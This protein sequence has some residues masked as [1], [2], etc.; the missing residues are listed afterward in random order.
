MQQ[1]FKENYI[2]QQK[3]KAAER[4]A[5]LEKIGMVSSSESESTVQQTPRVAR[6]PRPAE[7]AMRAVR[8]AQNPQSPVAAQSVNTA[9]AQPHAG[10][11]VRT[12]QPRPGVSVKPREVQRS[13]QPDVRR[14]AQ[15]QRPVS[16]SQQRPTGPQQRPTG[17]QQSPATPPAS[18]AA[19]PVRNSD[20]TAAKVKA[21]APAKA[22]TP[23]STRYG[24]PQKS[25]TIPSYSQRRVKE[26]T[27]EQLFKK[28]LS[29]D[30]SRAMMFAL[31][32]KAEKPDDG[33][34]VDIINMGRISA[35]KK[36]KEADMKKR[37]SVG[38]YIGR[39][40]AA[41]GAVLLAVIVFV[42]STVALIAHGKSM[43]LRDLLVNS[44]MQ[45]SATKWVPYVFLS[46]E[47]VEEILN[48]SDEV[49]EDKVSIED[50]NKEN[51]S[52]LEDEWAN[53]K[54]GMI[55][56]TVSGSTFKAYVLLIKDP[57]RVFVGTSVDDYSTATSG[58]DVFQAAERYGAVACTNG[59]EFLDN[60]GF[61]T[62]FKPMGL[63]YSQG[64]CVNNDGSKKT[65]LGIT[66]DN[67]LIVREEMTKKEADELHIRDAVSFQNGNTLIQRDGDEIIVHYQDGNTG[68]AQR[69]G[70]GQRADG[71]IILVVTDGRSASSLGATHNDMIDLMMSYGAVTA[72]LVDGGS[73][74]LMYYEDYFTKYDYDYSKLDK[75]QQKGLVNNYKAFTEPRKIPTFIMVE[76]LKEGE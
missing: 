24:A 49:V 60:G 73:S 29:D 31:T 68:T 6:T 47:T 57:S 63:T 4:R 74:A 20:N 39:F 35:P 17:P 7:N 67:V 76:P 34:D 2:R 5:R 9:K 56:E 48:K 59:G 71:T 32:G 12:A 42:F 13:S 62:G 10:Q 53:A 26:P 23:A 27:E 8:A 72:G 65:F 51:T 38:K 64:E 44:A 70:I 58:I 75:Y 33:G 19:R 18:V 30:E 43:T 45:A 40:F 61:G 41:L 3:Q 1:D 22:N 69:S 37:S 50:Y 52:D 11:P 66:E 25:G 14:A 54:D 16:Q 46:D 21:N 36:K 55:F 15:Q 28:Q